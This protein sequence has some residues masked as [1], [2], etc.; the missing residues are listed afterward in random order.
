MYVYMNGLHVIKRYFKKY[1]VLGKWVESHFQIL[2]SIQTHLKQAL[3]L[4]E[5]IA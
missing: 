5:V 1:D 3:F 4:L 2:V